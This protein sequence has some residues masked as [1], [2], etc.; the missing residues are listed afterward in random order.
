MIAL[1]IFLLTLSQ[2]ASCAPF[3][4]SLTRKYAAGNRGNSIPYYRGSLFCWLHIVA[5][6]SDL[7]TMLN[8]DGIV[9][10]RYRGDQANPI[11]QSAVLILIRFPNFPISS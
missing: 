2:L 10:R 8:A 1:C 6:M 5:A 4:V 7:T 11:P 9:L 3:S